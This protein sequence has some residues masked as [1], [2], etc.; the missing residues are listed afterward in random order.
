MKK[1]STII[2]KI[3]II[4]LIVELFLGYY[5][6][7]QNNKK[8]GFYVPAVYKGFLVVLRNVKKLS[9]DNK[10]LTEIK[11]SKNQVNEKNYFVKTFDKE[12]IKY[13]P[14]ID[15]SGGP[16]TYET[17]SGKF[18]VDRDYFGF[19][20][21]KPLNYNEDNKKF[22]IILSGGS[23]CLGEF[24][25]IPIS[26]ILTNQLNEHFNT[27]KIIVF[28]LCMN[29]HTISN[30]IQNLVHIGYHYNPSLIISH[31]GWN[32]SKYFKY[33]PEKFKKTALIYYP[34]QINWYDKLYDIKTSDG[35]RKVSFKESDKKIFKESLKKNVIKYRK[36]AKSFNSD[37][38]IGIQPYDKNKNINKIDLE[39]LNAFENQIEEMKIEKI[40][41]TKL[42]ES[43]HFVDSSHTSQSAAYK[44]SDIY[45]NY[46]KE[47]H[48]EKILKKISKT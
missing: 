16:K 22:A 17:S 32:D 8:Y 23:E 46:I 21:S 12:V 30:E 31:T 41:F 36:I 27:D 15:V 7:Q 34:S 29:S 1:S 26:Q 18:S 19:R 44:I 39:F 38:I 47:N 6:F 2:Y 42:S 14:F 48:S 45:F 4:V 40:N 28:N 24:H 3:L 13:H 25:K 9:L 37:L 33:I 11:T 35:H 10:D 43:F 20:N 5:A